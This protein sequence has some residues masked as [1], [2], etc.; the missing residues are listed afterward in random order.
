MIWHVVGWEHALCRVFHPL[1][2]GRPSCPVATDRCGTLKGT[3]DEYG[4]TLVDVLDALPDHARLVQ[5][6]LIRHEGVQRVGVPI[7]HCQ[8]RVPEVCE[9]LKLSWW[10]N[11][12]RGFRS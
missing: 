3:V 6:Y 11:G 10:L 5:E 12:D 9:E 4:C 8:V 2:C 1:R 7:Q